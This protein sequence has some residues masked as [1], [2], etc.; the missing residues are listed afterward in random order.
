MQ[1][2][3]G[4]IS[5]LTYLYE[6]NEDEIETEDIN[7]VINLTAE[8]QFAEEFGWYPMLYTFSKE[9]FIPISQ[10][11]STSALE[12]LTFVNFFKRKCQLDN[13]RIAKGSKSN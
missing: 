5:N 13:E 4:V 8:A 2:K 3:Q 12:F 6:D 10:V 7:E 11:V 9:Q 1:F